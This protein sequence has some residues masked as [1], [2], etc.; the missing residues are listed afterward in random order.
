MSYSETIADAIAA[1]SL[2]L[3]Q[4]FLDDSKTNHYVTSVFALISSIIF[5]IFT[6]Y[7]LVQTEKLVAE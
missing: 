4:E 5:C 7:I 1:E 3:E 6:A 2:I